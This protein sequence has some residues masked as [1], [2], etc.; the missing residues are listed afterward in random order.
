MTTDALPT[1]SKLQRRWPGA[2]REERRAMIVDAALALLHHQGLDAVT[3]RKVADRLGVGA[4]T[5]Y[6]YIGGQDELRRALTQRGFELMR[7]A[8]Q[9]HDPPDARTK[10]RLAGH[11]YVQF[12]L[13]HP[14]LYQLMFA[15]PVGDDEADGDLLRREFEP[16]VQVVRERMQR[17]GMAEDQID[18]HQTRAALRYWVTLHGVAS[19]AI[20][21]R[22]QLIES[23]I[24]PII[25][26]LI[27]RVSPT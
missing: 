2:D 15:T 8:C 11:S 9:E 26:D 27:D 18:A 14:K 19:L 7:Q 24:G 16:L 20:A 6:T 13:A 12:A 23:D 25:D 21:S 17:A 10:W 3:M 1:P 4:M 5:L 22:V